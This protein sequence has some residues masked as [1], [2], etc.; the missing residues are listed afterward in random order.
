MKSLIRHRSNVSNVISSKQSGSFSH[1]YEKIKLR[2]KNKSITQLTVIIP[3][4]INNALVFCLILAR[5]LVE[6]HVIVMISN[7][8]TN[9]PPSITEPIQGPVT[10]HL[11]IISIINIIM[12]KKVFSIFM[13]ITYLD[14]IA[15]IFV[16][17][18][19]Y[20]T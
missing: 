20:S 10:A 12:K 3:M 8:A 4:L 14:Q 15:P 17:S 5:Y 19:T 6:S 13:Y 16:A 18:F 1:S 2:T 9:N 11:A 7:H